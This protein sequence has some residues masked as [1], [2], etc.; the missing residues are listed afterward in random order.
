MMRQLQRQ[1][2]RVVR[3]EMGEREEKKGKGKGAGKV[4]VKDKGKGDKILINL[5]FVDGGKMRELN[6][7]FRKVDKIT[8]VLSFNLKEENSSTAAKIAGKAIIAGEIII[9]VEQAQ[10]NAQRFG[11]TVTNEI[12]RLLTHGMLHL[13]GYDHVRTKERSSMRQKEEEYA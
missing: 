9:C 7:E 8:D 3:G 2:V 6:R 10:K 13:A 12:M 4:K 11:V 1:A 5:V